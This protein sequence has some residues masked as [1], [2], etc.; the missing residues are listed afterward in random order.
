MQWHQMGY[1]QTI[2]TSLQTRQPHQHPNTQFL[3]AGYSS[4]RPTNGVK[5]LMAKTII[6]LYHIYNTARLSRSTWNVF[7]SCSLDVLK[8]NWALP[9][10]VSMQPISTNRQ[11]EC[12]KA[13]WN[14]CEIWSS[15]LLKMFG[16]Q[17]TCD[18]KHKLTCF[19]NLHSVGSLH[20]HEWL[21]G[22][23]HTHRFFRTTLAWLGIR[24]VS[25]L[26]SGAEGPGFKSQSRRCRVT[27]LGKLFTPIEH[28]FTKQQNW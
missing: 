12:N 19:T 9:A 22:L 8:I 2:C 18:S 27:V 10:L 1:M 14:A 6:Q 13:T 17:K 26:N 7:N 5:T 23:Y 4:W 15:L 25:V 28:L 21:D 11:H 16:K 3:Q 24:V 20:P